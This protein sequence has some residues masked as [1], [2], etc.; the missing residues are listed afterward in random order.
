MQQNQ[1]SRALTYVLAGF[2][3]LFFFLRF[4]QLGVKPMHHDE[5]VNAF[6]FQNLIKTGTFKY[7]PANYHGPALYYIQL[8][9]T[10]LDSLG[11]TNFLEGITDVSIRTGVA[12]AGVLVLLGLLWASH[13]IGRWGALAA[14]L[15]AGFSCDLLYF[16]RYFI[17]EIFVVL[18]TLGIYLG[19]TRYA[20]TRKPGFLYLMAASASLLYCTKETS[21]LIMGVLLISAFLTPLTHWLMSPS[22]G[23]TMPPASNPFWKDPAFQQHLLISL[24]LAAGIWAFLYSSFF[25]NPQGLIDSLK[26][27][28][29]WSR[30]GTEST[31]NKEFSYFM[32][33]LLIKY[34]FAP[35][36]LSLFGGLLAFILN[37]KKG[38]FLAYWTMGLLLV[39]SIIPYKTPW[40]VI[41][42]LLPMFLLSGYGVQTLINKISDDESIQNKKASFTALAVGLSL[43]LFMQTPQT[44]RIVFREYDNEKHAQAYA[45]TVRDI[46]RLIDDI[47]FIARMAPEREEIRINI[48]STIDWPLPY[49][50][51]K[52][53]KAL[54]WERIKDIGPV[55]AP[56]IISLN[57][58]EV[59]LKPLLKDTY[60]T[61]S[62]T[63]RPGVPL[64]LFIN[65]RYAKGFES[66]ILRIP[67]F[68]V[69]LQP[70]SPLLPGLKQELFKGSQFWGSPT[71]STRQ[72]LSF[73]WS[74]DEDKPAQGPFSMIW[75]G[76]L[77]IPAAGT[78]QFSL[79]SDDGSWLF[80]DDT[81]VIDNGG[82]HIST[83][84]SHAAILSAGF[85]KIQIKYFD[86]G[87]EAI[88]HILWAPPKAS[89]FT[90][91]SKAFFHSEK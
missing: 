43:L 6:F 59:E 53:P 13:R 83:V 77:K 46:Y 29:I 72:D 10:W 65:E 74:S 20:D 78:Y 86:I 71:D 38:L 60:L 33:N 26:T 5:G 63:L 61:K 27:F 69:S 88:F 42:L 52:Y 48:V 64:V 62:Y 23:K 15:L 90:P 24:G 39:H 76:Y 44:L 75:S 51:R 14:F 82:A 2:F 56:M 3:L 79:E 89:G 57:R 32:N 54:F 45:H 67:H 58:Q 12:T 68:S 30:T 36:V 7:D 17:H 11:K 21:V 28:L 85:H 81:L 80:I 25:K 50:L 1:P 37:E 73:F 84:K 49:Y 35:T 70:K 18:F 8:L 40:L 22:D 4:H 34:E 9:P 87:G 19:G 55:D 31:H 16:S 41:T 91:L 66:Q 47:G